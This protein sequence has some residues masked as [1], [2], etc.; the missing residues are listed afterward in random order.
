MKDSILLLEDIHELPYR[1]DRMFN[2]LR[3]SKVLKQIKGVILGHF[4]DCFEPDPAKQSFTL[5]EIIIEY[6]QGQKIPVIYLCGIL[7]DNL[8]LRL[9]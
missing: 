3:L 1:I 4:V 5:N 8:G 2:Q 6:F 7:F 9:A